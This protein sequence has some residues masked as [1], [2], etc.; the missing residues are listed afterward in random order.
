MHKQ[1]INKQIV[2]ITIVVHHLD[3]CYSKSSRKAFC[4]CIHICCKWGESM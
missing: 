4:T 1:R 2:N 3:N